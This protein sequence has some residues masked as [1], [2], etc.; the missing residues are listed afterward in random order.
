MFVKGIMRP[1][2]R[3]FYLQPTLKVA[4]ELLG[5][6]L[7]HESAEGVAGGIIVETEGYLGPDDPGS[8]SRM[9]R[10]DRNA[11]M[12]GPGGHAYVYVMHTHALLNIITGPENVPQGVLIRALA[13]TIGLELMR[14]RRGV[15]RVKDLCSGPG[16]LTEAL[17]IAIAEYGADM[18]K[19]PLYVS[20]EKAMDGEI[21]VTTRIGLRPEKGADLAHRFYFAGNPYI[22][23]R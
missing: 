22:S 19:P 4:R 21:T 11:V 13:P 17:G 14:Q 9:G 6:L 12:F 16:K 5:H 2:S 8:H 18:T 20:S 7:I 1:L 15:E 3:R 10:T 23:R